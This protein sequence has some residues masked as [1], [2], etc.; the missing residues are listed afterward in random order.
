M[1]VSF[2][3]NSAEENIFKKLLHKYWYSSS[4]I[5]VPDVDKEKQKDLLNFT[6]KFPNSKFADD[7]MFVVMFCRP[8]VN[9]KIILT[10]QMVK[11]YP[12]GKLEAYTV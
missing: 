8:D 12:N 2:A 11:Q 5:F 9:D 7:A 6:K 4:T 1:K 10:E 3:Q